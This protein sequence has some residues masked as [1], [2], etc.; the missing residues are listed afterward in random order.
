MRAPATILSDAAQR[1]ARLG[2]CKGSYYF[3][4]AH[5]PLSACAIGAIHLALHETAAAPRFESALH[6]QVDIV[7]CLLAERITGREIEDGGE[8]HE[9]VTDWNDAE[10]RTHAEVLAA[11][12]GDA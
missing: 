3:G 6:D 5:D 11:L 12:R 8:A 1:F 7:T 9:I 2:L 10:K 4:P